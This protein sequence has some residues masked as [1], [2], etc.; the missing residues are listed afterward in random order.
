MRTQN[1]EPGHVLIVGAAA[2][3]LATVE[4]LRRQGCGS[5]IT[6]L[7]D[8]VHPPYDRPPLSKQVLAGS[9]KPEQAALRPVE[10]LESLDV[11]FILGDAA[12]ALE[13]IS[14]TVRTESGRLIQADIIV[15]ATGVTARTLSGTDEWQGVHSIRTLDDSIALQ[16]DLQRAERLVVVGEG[17][18]GAEVAATAR[19]LGIDDVV[20]AGPQPAPMTLQLGPFGSQQLARLHMQ[21]GVKLRLGT[22]VSGLE[23]EGGR[24]TGVR[25]A[26]G[27]LLPADVVV[28]AIGATPSTLW[29]EGSGLTLGDGVVCDEQCRAAD[30]V[31]VVGDVARWHHRVLGESV[32]LENRTNATEQAT[33]VASVILGER[34]PYVPVPYFW[35]DQFGVKVQVYGQLPADAS[36]EIVEGDVASDRFVAAYRRKGDLVGVL[37]WS[38]PKQARLHSR[39]LVE[40]YKQHQAQPSQTVP[41]RSVP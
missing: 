16:K 39:E 3:G 9:W 30:G 38:M 17:V 18:L 25:L 13:P 12:V 29:L 36:V 6:V 28:V 35:T 20:L 41:E 22:A 14:R 24:V 34:K 2:A 21:N 11:E 32:R 27:Q 37:G 5:R 8:E 23:G 7:G 31:F 33:A 15:I 40:D 4:A 1:A 26:S 10:Y 19:S